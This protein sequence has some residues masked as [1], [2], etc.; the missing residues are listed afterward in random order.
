MAEGMY[1]PAPALA[2]CWK[3]G[4]GGKS[5]SQIEIAGSLC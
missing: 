5:G 2:R 1:H 3:H 4:L